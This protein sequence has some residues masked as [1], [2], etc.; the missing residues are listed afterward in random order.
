[1]NEECEEVPVISRLFR[2]GQMFQIALT[3][4]Y[5][6]NY[7]EGA[8]I[9]EATSSEIPSQFETELISRLS[10]AQLIRQLQKTK[11]QPLSTFRK[12]FLP[13]FDA[14]ENQLVSDLCVTEREGLVGEIISEMLIEQ[15]FSNF[16]IIHRN[17]RRSGRANRE[18]MDFLGIWNTNGQE[19]LALVESK[20][21]GP[22]SQ[23]YATYVRARTEEALEG[24]INYRENEIKLGKALGWVI[25]HELTEPFSLEQSAKIISLFEAGPRLSSASITISEP[26]DVKSLV[27]N[28]PTLVMTVPRQVGL[29]LAF[30]DFSENS[31]LKN[32]VAENDGSD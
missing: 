13:N 2:S 12:Q 20:Y 3:I 31:F 22:C 28:P 17:W 11:E 25:K 18:G 30:L 16:Q 10:Q 21:C 4:L 26:L 27:Q 1:L 23:S 5:D 8:H 24:M 15:C 7:K 14:L 29:A 6:T 9:V 32:L 19:Y